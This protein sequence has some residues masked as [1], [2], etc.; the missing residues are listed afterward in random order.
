MCKG[1]TNFNF[2]QIDSQKGIFVPYMNKNYPFDLD[3]TQQ[4]SKVWLAI[5]WQLINGMDLEHALLL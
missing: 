2:Y 1:A 5:R 3:A 4:Q